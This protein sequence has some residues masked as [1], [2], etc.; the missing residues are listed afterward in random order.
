M[1]EKTRLAASAPQAD[2]A[3]SLAQ[4]SQIT[5]RKKRRQGGPGRPFVPGQSGNPGGRP[6][7]VLGIQR[8][9]LERCEEAIEKLV[10]LMREAESERAQ[11]Q[12]AMAILDRGCGKPTQPADGRLDVT[13]HAVPIAIAGRYVRGCSIS[14]RHRAIAATNR[15]RATNVCIHR[16]SITLDRH[17][18]SL[19][20]RSAPHRWEDPFG[21]RV[22]ASTSLAG[23]G[24][25]VVSHCLSD[26]GEHRRGHLESRASPFRLR[27]LPTP[28]RRERTRSSR[29]TRSEGVP[30]RHN[31]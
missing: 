28:A 7:D 24:I 2:D 19:T 22:A 15:P 3:A 20:S 18:S 27:D 14:W 26:E 16:S 6:K 13:Y 23:G 12:A 1:A 8:L 5:A 17:S 21:A 11:A 25:G 30:R 4:N 29:L 9:A 31:S 10:K